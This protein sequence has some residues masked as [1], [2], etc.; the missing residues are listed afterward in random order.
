MRGVL[1]PSLSSVLSP[2]PGA[3]RLFSKLIIL[4]DSNSEA[5][6]SGINAQNRLYDEGYTDRMPQWLNLHLNGRFSCVQNVYPGQT[7]KL[8]WGFGG[9]GPENL[10]FG[11]GINSAQIPSPYPLGYLIASATDPSDTLVGI[12]AGTNSIHV[13]GL[14]GIQTA[15]AVIS[16]WDAVA[17]AG[18]G[19]FGVAILPGPTNAKTIETRAANVI[20]AAEAASRGIVWVPVPSGFDDGTDFADAYANSDLVHLN[21]RGAQDWASAVAA[22]IDHLIQ[23]DPISTLIPPDGSA[24]WLSPNPYFNGGAVGTGWFGVFN[25][26]AGATVT[27]SRITDAEGNWVRYTQTGAA[28]NGVSTMGL[29]TT[30]ANYPLAGVHYQCVAH[31]RFAGGAAAGISTQHGNGNTVGFM[32][33]ALG[34]VSGTQADSSPVAFAAGGGYVCSHPFI[35]R[36]TSEANNMRGYIIGNGTADFRF[37]GVIARPDLD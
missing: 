17:A 1:S 31:I 8:H 33:R 36:A 22:A 16:L 6:N 10:Q 4:G 2:R 7:Q 27:P 37:L 28:A 13:N 30:F 5:G 25:T 9:C 19:Y 18:F 11:G 23:P 21:N 12:A 20:L 34:A 3:A 35:A 32:N 29:S 15:A 26:A 14:N 24:L